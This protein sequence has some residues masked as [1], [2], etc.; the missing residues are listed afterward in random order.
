MN[1]LIL[2]AILAAPSPAADS[3]PAP[4]AK[5]AERESRTYLVRV[6]RLPAANGPTEYRAKFFFCGQSK[7]EWNSGSKKHSAKG[8]EL[9]SYGDEAHSFGLSVGEGIGTDSAVVVAQFT[10]K[11]TKDLCVKAVL[12][13]VT[14]ESARV[15]GF[16]AEKVRFDDACT[17]ASWE[18]DV[19]VVPLAF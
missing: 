17:G 16:T 11:G 18:D 12:G 9:A 5:N 2:A 7:L 4:C 8:Y 13:T 15:G 3:N 10:G 14:K 1:I 19:Q 6:K